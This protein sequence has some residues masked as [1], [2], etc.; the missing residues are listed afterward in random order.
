M[1]GIKGDEHWRWRISA[2]TPKRTV[3]HL[4]LGFVEAADVDIFL[5]A[6]DELA[7]SLAHNPHVKPTTVSVDISEKQVFCELSCS[8]NLTDLLRQIETDCPTIQK[9]GSASAG[10][11]VRRL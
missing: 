2:E 10:R 8:C 4:V 9:N 7:S 6:A 1:S 11:F 5:L 3:G